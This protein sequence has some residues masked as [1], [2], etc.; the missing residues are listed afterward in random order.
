MNDATE[1]VDSTKTTI[2]KAG[3]ILAS[4][5]EPSITD[6]TRRA[7]ERLR[8]T[9][10]KVLDR[11]PADD[12]KLCARGVLEDIL[13]VLEQAL[14]DVSFVHCQESLSL[15]RYLDA[16]DLSRLPMF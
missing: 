8:R 9:A 15:T 16:S 2:A 6:K 13:R 10:T 5:V 1:D 3:E 11:P 12:A 14:T 4:P 7:L